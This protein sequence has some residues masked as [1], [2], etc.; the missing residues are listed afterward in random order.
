MFELRDLIR[1]ENHILGTFM[2]NYQKKHEEVQSKV[3]EVR[4]D[5]ILVAI[6]TEYKT[7]VYKGCIDIRSNVPNCKEYVGIKHNYK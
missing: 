2:R 4:E 6:S 5:Y 7:V 1:I 3:I